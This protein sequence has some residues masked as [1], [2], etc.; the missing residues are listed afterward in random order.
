MTYVLVAQCFKTG[1]VVLILWKM[2]LSFHLC[3]LPSQPLSHHHPTTSTPARR[4]KLHMLPFATC[5][6][7]NF[8]SSLSPLDLGPAFQNSETFRRDN[9]TLKKSPSQMLC[10]LLANMPHNKL[11]GKEEEEGKRYQRFTWFWNANE[12]KRI[13]SVP[14]T[15]QTA[16]VLYLLHVELISK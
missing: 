16:N 7:C 6:F 10:F 3:L 2:L 8:R 11:L 5:F 1:C 4:K 12:Y 14:F 13:K 15:E 9:H